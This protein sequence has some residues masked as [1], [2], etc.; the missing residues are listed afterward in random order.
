MK[1]TEYAAAKAV[2]LTK[3]ENSLL[4]K[5]ESKY[6]LETPGVLDPMPVAN[7][8]SGAVAHV[9]PIVAAL[10]AFVYAANRGGPFD[11]LS[12]NGHPVSVSDFDRTRYLVLKLDSAAYS[13]LLD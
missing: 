11:P 7:Q 8:I 4:T 1:L 13:A 3:P 5:L 6:G 2:K 10:V 9:S 12:Y